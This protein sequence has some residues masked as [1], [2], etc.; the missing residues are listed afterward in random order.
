MSSRAAS[1]RAAPEIMFFRN[2]LCPGA[3]MMMYCAR[4]DQKR[5]RRID[6]DPLLLLFKKRV[7]QE[8]VLKF[9]ALLTTDGLHFLKLALREGPCVRIQTAQQR[10]LS[11]VNMA[12]DDDVQCFGSV[13]YTGIHL[14]VTF[15]CDPQAR[16][17]HAAVDYGTF[18]ASHVSSLPKQLHAATFILRPSR[19]L[20]HIRMS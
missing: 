16:F 6:R 2:S 13:G 11:M 18:F 17:H 10:R 1:A 8:R 20:R 9:F 7:E 15:E 5:S 14:T 12:D 3:S 19:P 4:S